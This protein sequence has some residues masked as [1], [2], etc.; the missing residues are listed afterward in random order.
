MSRTTEH[1]EGKAGVKAVYFTSKTLADGSHPFLIRITKNRVRKYI[2]T[3]LALHPKFWNEQKNEIRRS[4]PE[5]YRSTLLEELRKW[6]EKYQ[7]AAG[8]LSTADE[9][10]DVKAVAR[11]AVEHRKATRRVQV[12]AYLDEVIATLT[13]AKQTGNTRVYKDFR[14]QLTKFVQAKYQAQDLPCERKD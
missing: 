6:E 2:A 3:G 10:H 1:K 14:N 12:L 4:Y 11:K 13:E 9:N 5:P 8:T 7:H